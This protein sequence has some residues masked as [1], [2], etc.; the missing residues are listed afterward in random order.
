MDVLFRGILCDPS[1]LPKGPEVE[2]AMA[3]ESTKTK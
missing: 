3:G 2:P 1:A